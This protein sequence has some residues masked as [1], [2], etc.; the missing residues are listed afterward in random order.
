MEY[1]AYPY[2]WVVLGVF[3]LTNLAIQILWI[4]YAPIT[5][6]AAGYYGVSDLLIGLLS[7][8]FMI[9]FIPL[10]I[11]A[12]WAIDTLGFRKSVSIGAAMMGMFGVLRGFAG[13]NYT[14]VLI[15]TFGLAM[16]HKPGP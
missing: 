9:A 13:G 1:K 2:R 10:S 7:M 14:L 12:S 3:M 5:G 15:A 11:P 4:S 6:P 8:S 16:R